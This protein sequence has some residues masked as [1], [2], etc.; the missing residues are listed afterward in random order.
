MGQPELS[1]SEHSSEEGDSLVEREFQE[2]SIELAEVST[3]GDELPAIRTLVH[4]V[5]LACQLSGIIY[6][7]YLF[8]SLVNL[9]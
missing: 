1:V 5:S 6:S 8:R 7:F 3:Q 2:N 4:S 9:F